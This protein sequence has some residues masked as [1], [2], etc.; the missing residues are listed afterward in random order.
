MWMRAAIVKDL[1]AAVCLLVVALRPDLA[2]AGC[3]DKIDLFPTS[4]GESVDA[5]GLAYLRSDEDGANQGQTRLS[6]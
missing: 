5:R 4:D 1:L 6:R 2:A 3:A